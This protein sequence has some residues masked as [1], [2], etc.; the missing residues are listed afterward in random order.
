MKFHGVII[1]SHGL[2]KKIQGA[3]GRGRPQKAWIDKIKEW[4][5]DPVTPQVAA[6]DRT[7]TKETVASSLVP[8]R[9][10]GLQD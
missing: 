5:F 9:C 4:I 8:Q 7:L 2:A 10:P 1:R 3:R 6:L